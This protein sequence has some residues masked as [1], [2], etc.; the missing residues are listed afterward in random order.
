MGDKSPK[1]KHRAEKQKG[2]AKAGRAA[3]AKSKQ[4]SHSSGAQIALKR[5]K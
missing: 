3:E 2:V 1:S 4:D 5:K